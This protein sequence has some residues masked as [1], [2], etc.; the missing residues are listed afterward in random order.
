MTTERLRVLIIIAT[1][2]IGGPG[3]GLFQFLSS[4]GGDD[5][6]YVLC[7]FAIPGRGDGEFIDEARRRGLDLALLNQPRFLVPGVIRQ[8]ARIVAERRISVI[9]TH[10]YKSNLIGWC[11]RRLCGRPWVAFAHGYTH[12]NWKM[13]MYN[14]LDLAVMRRADRIVTVS[15]SMKNLL[16]RHGVQAEKIRLIYNAIPPVPDTSAAGPPAALLASHG[17]QPGRRVVGVIGRLNPEKGQMVFL[18]A[19]RR[20][21]RSCPDVT[22][23]LVGDGQDRESL[24]QFCAAHGLGPH[25]VFTG[26]RD[27]VADYY[28]ALDLFV[29]PSLSEGLPNAVLEAM[30]FG[31]PVLATRV[32]GVPEIITSDNG[33]MVPPADPDAL[34]DAM[35]RL[36]Q[37]DDLRLRMGVRGRNSLYPR[38]SPEQRVREILDVYREVLR[39]PGMS[40]AAAS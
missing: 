2:A 40:A 20:V 36:L 16:L 35:I 24:Q 38:F 9:Q 6:E 34:A 26:Y 11:L 37:D 33:L 22:A 7:N 25:V 15:S 13:R 32:G 3:K 23:L 18:Q 12:D 10:G 4:V 1:D 21:T 28:R 17:I 5:G 19:L 8:A 14:R 29:L 27:N 39:L 30:S 31:V